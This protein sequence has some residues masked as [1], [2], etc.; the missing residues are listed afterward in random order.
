AEIAVFFYA[1]HGLQ[2][3]G[4]NYLVPVDARIEDETD[5]AFAALDLQDVVQVMTRSALVS[6]VFLDACR[7][8]PMADQLART[9]GTRS[10]A[11][12]R[13]LARVESGVGTLVAYATQP[14]NVALDG[15]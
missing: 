5:L 7:D 4:V 10:T 9:L 1:G 2:V 11:V 8:N 3:D 15:S 13:G 6:L 14:G 12:G